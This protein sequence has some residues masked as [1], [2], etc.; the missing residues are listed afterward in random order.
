MEDLTS[1]WPRLVRGETVSNRSPWSDGER[2]VDSFYRGV[3]AKIEREQRC[4]SRNEWSHYGSGYASFVEAWF[5]RDDEDFRRPHEPKGQSFVGL[6][7][8]LSRLSEFYVLGRGE[9]SWSKTTAG[10]FLPELAFVDR[11]TD[12]PA[13]FVQG[14]EHT[15][16]ACGLVRLRREQLEAELPS[17]T[18]VPTILADP[19]YRFFDALFHWED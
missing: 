13:D 8:L 18:E 6:A 11:L 9:K 17:A 3:V 4:R 1:L 19:P 2:K 7:V 15:L 14:V 16:S 10:S 12:L 5:Y